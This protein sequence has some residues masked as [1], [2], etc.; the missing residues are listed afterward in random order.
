MIGIG[1]RTTIMSVMMLTT[2]AIRR[3][4]SSF[5]QPLPSL[6]VQYRLTGVHS[7]TVAK[8]NADIIHQKIVTITSKDQNVPIPHN[9]TIIIVAHT[10]RLYFV[11]CEARRYVHNADILVKVMRMMKITWMIHCILK[12]FVSYAIYIR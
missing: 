3:R 10:K 12:T 2:V 8:K 4:A 6:L 11:P 9:A 1:I 5:E 7:N